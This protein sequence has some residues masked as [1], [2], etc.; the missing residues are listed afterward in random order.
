MHR[1]DR[2]DASDARCHAGPMST[3]RHVLVIGCGIGGPVVAMALQ[4]AGIDA[5][6][7]EAFDRPADAVGSFLN[8]STNGIVA[9]RAIGADRRVLDI[10]FPTPRMVM[11]SGT[12]KRLGEVA[13]GLPL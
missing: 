2:K 6:I 1:N 11:W 3:P 7:F 5:T 9:L 8:L 13:N 10:G 12:G 4:R